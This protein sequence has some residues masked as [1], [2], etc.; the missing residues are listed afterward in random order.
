[1]K[2]ILAAATLGLLGLAATPALAQTCGQPYVV[3]GGDTLSGIANRVYQDAGMWTTIHNANIE[4]IG[5]KP[6]L[7]R[8]GMRLTLACQTTNTVVATAKPVTN[9]QLTSAPSKPANTAMTPAREKIFIVTGDDF[10]PFTDRGLENNGLLAEVVDR[11]MDASVGSDGYQTFWI[12][13]WSS[14]LNAM[15][16]AGVVEMAFP[17]AQPDCAG[18]PS[19]TRCQQFHFS[20][21]IFEYLVLLYVDKSRPIPFNT[22]ADMHGRTLC[23]PAGYLTHM[24][25][26]D[27]RNWVADGTVTLA[28]PDKVSDC[29]E[30][31]ANG[32]VDGVVLNEFTARDAIY[33]MDLADTIEP[34]MSQPISITGLHVLVEKSNP[35]S[36][37]LLNKIDVGLAAIKADGQ[38]EEIVNRHMA[39]IWAG[40]SA[41]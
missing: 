25:D 12:N 30:M 39:S 23:R 4:T 15:M 2:K 8:V 19:Q 17:W 1:M 18:D 9:V 22:D 31:L 33:S 13:D 38:Y 10:A 11:A 26:K 7:L 28:R 35:R 24:L 20:T 6:N 40:Y 36:A 27:G 34:V 16:P 32:E 3:K 5:P 37:D 21:P 29:F 41:Q 14:H